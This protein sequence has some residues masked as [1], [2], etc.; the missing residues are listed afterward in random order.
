MIGIDFDEEYAYAG[1]KIVAVVR[2]TRAPI[3]PLEM[4]LDTGSTVSTMNHLLLEP[5]GIR[6]VETGRPGSLAVANGE[7]AVCWVHPVDIQAFGRAYSIDVAFCPEW[8]LRNLLGMR[9]FMDQLVFAVDHA[10]HRLYLKWRE[11]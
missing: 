9:G 11:P 5:L 6:D 10:E 4:V 1:D 8:N 2:L 3:F 7:T